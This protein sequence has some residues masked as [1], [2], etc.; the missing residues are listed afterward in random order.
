[1]DIL[2]IFDRVDEINLRVKELERKSF[3]LEGFYLRIQI[4]EF[5]V[6]RAI[7]H[8]E[9]WVRKLINRGGLKYIGNNEEALKGKTLGEL[10]GLLSEHCKDE[11]L[12]SR[13]NGINS[14]RKRIVHRLLEDKLPLGSI[15]MKRSI[16]Y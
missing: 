1:M 6:Q 16:N 9:E 3:Y 5:L 8:Q 10:I 12:I 13:L 15:D 7:V 4:I 11:Q 14:F 2:E